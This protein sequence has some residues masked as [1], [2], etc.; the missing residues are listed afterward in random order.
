MFGVFLCAVVFSS[1]PDVWPKQLKIKRSVC[2]NVS[3]DLPAL[4]MQPTFRLSGC[5]RPSGS[6]DAA[7]LPALR[8]QSTFRLSGCSR[9]SGSPDAADLPALRMQSTFRLSG[10]SRPS[11]SPD[12]VDLPALPEPHRIRTRAEIVGAGSGALGT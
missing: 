5:S 8:M 9:P 1:L 10:C 6:P 4:R 12:A 11:G 7:D 2:I 3:A